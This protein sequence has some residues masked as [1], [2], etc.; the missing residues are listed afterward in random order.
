MFVAFVPGFAF[1]TLSPKSWEKKK[2]CWE[3]EN[4]A[5]IINTS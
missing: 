5:G 3:E 1:T 4:W 2:N